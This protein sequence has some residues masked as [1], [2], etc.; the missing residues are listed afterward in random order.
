MLVQL[1][2]HIS[3]GVGLERDCRLLAALLRE[4]GHQVQLVDFRRTHDATQADLTI[5]LEVVN[6]YLLRACEPCWLVPN[7]EWWNKDWDEFLFLFR[8]ILCKT[9]EIGRAHV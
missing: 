1:V 7:P 9:R 6:P 5:F 4:R 8:R 3:N 2:S